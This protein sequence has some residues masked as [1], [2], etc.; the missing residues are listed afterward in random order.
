MSEKSTQNIDITLR[1]KEP[2]IFIGWIL[3][4]LI[5][6]GTLWALTQPFQSRTLAA[7]VNRV[8][9]QSGD[10]RRLDEL[11]A[12][13]AI[14]FFGTGAWFTLTQESQIQ[15]AAVGE[16]TRV[17]IFAFLGES[18]FFPCAAFVNAEGR[19]VEFFPLNNHGRRIISRI[20]PEILEIHARRIEGNLL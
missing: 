20:S 5:V 19:V 3:A 18:T 13:G 8:L 6:A 15:G 2:V 12:N 17:V 16:G 14:G 7:A 1:A 10:P 9:E 4:I 11:S